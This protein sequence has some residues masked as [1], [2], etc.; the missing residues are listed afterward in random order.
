MLFGGTLPQGKEIPLVDVLVDAGADLDFQRC[1]EDGKK[2]DTPLI[3]AA[4]LG[5]EDVGLRLLAD[6]ARPDLRGLF[7]ETAL[8]WA[9]LLGEDRLVAELIR[10]SN[11]NLRDEKY[12]SPPLGWAI[13]GWCDPP[14]G[15]HGRQREVVAL[16][17]TAGASV[18]P[19]W[20]ER[21]RVRAD[22]QMLAALGRG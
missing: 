9:A 16:L 19:E 6:G 18:E 4:S 15:N 12:N 3:G 14:A 22:P 10:G 1:R 7:G 2:A 17:V 5:A 20:L 13:H 21:E 11:V 8:H